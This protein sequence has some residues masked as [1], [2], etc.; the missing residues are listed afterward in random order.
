M[1]L[2]NGPI[3]IQQEG[4]NPQ[5][6]SLFRYYGNANL[7]KRILEK[8][9]HSVKKLRPKSKPSFSEKNLYFV[10]IFDQT[11]KSV[12]ISIFRFWKM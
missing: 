2:A 12:Q 8:N 9:S 10:S 6:L 4:E 11:H 3:R 7:S 5:R 1:F